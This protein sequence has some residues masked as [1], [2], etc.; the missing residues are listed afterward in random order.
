MKVNWEDVQEDY[1]RLNADI[2]ELQVELH[3]AKEML[4]DLGYK[5]CDSIECNCGG[6]H[7][8]K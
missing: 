7:V 2:H 6:Y 1:K 8:E 4:R 5:R 3:S